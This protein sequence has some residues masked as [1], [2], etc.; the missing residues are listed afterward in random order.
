ML[1]IKGL[2]KNFGRKVV[3]DHL[4]SAL[5]SGVYGLLGPNGSGKT[6]L[7]R[8]LTLTYTEGRNSIF[9]EGI[10][11]G[12]MKN[13]LDRLGYLPQTF[14]LFKDLKVREMMQMLAN[15]R[16]VGRQQARGDIEKCLEL[17]NLT[18][19]IESRISTL[20]GGMI[21]RLGIAQAFLG[22][23]DVMLFDEPTAGLDPIERLRFKSI[24]SETANDKTV[25]IST[26]IV[27][28]VEALCKK[29]LILKDGKF[30]V[31]GSTEEVK[32]LAAN[33]VYDIPD[34]DI[35]QIRGKHFVYKKYELSDQIR[36][37]FISAEKQDFAAVTPTIEDG[38]LCI[39][40]NY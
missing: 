31:D 33:K 16:G 22:D 37:R 19:K 21:R 4:T 15:L 32:Q 38:Y 5:E 9:Y 27:E 24:I 40:E 13:Y 23:P 6:T 1:E 12:K 3:L 34:T 18:D 8:C 29:I 26:H 35:A 20:S 28:D 30:A 10:S 25:I 11:L 36:L 39:M 7:L 17:V 14:G 2:N